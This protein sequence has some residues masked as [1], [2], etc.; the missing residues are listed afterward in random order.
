MFGRSNSHELAPAPL[1][2]DADFS[3]L[4]HRSDTRITECLGKIVPIKAFVSDYR[5]PFIEISREHLIGDQYVLWQ[6]NG[7]ENIENSS[8]PT[9]DNMAVL[10]DSNGSLTRFD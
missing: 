5:S 3:V 9:I 4:H 6:V 10:T 8:T 2:D 7:A 1:L